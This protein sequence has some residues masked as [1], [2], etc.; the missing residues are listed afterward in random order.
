M[1]Q[2][3]RQGEM[4]LLA[5]WL[6][7]LPAGYSSKTHVRV[8]EQPIQYQGIPLTPAQ[9]RAFSVWNSWA[10]ARVVTPSEVWIVEAKIVGTGAA[11]GQVL[12]YVGEYPASPDAQQSPGKDVIPVVLTMAVRPL[13]ASRFAAMGVRTIEFQPSFGLAESLAKLFPAAQ[14]LFPTGVA[15]DPAD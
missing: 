2:T 15:T 3:N 13:T 4:Q 9:S 7:Q 6:T 5:E 14:V 10:D 8:G 1:K 11:Y 12:D